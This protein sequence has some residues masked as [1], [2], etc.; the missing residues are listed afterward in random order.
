MRARA[1]VLDRLRA[2]TTT[3]HEHATG[4]PTELAWLLVTSFRTLGIAARFTSGYRIAGEAARLH[5][6]SEV[7]LPGAGWIGLDPTDGLFA[8]DAYVPLACTPDPLRALPI[9]G[10][11]EACDETTREEVVVQV[12][13]PE[14][15]AWPLDDD[16][17]A[18]VRALG[19]CVDADLDAGQT[20]LA[21]GRE[22]AFVSS[23]DAGR[24]E[25]STVALGDG[26][27]QAADALVEALPRGWHRAASSR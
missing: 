8:T 24:P 14:P 13:A 4:T 18:A 12:L 1:Y 26:K 3:V 23:R 9:T 2:V 20:R 19:A 22:L 21:V 11:R 17:W 16:A 5:A 25:W 7:Y 10:F 15:P 27:R 6:W